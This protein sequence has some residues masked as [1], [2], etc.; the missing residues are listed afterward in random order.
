MNNRITQPVSS[1]SRPLLYRGL[2]LPTLATLLLVLGALVGR[3]ALAEAPLAHGQGLLWKVESEGTAPSYL[4]G[5]MHVTDPG[6]TELP[7]PV[8]KAFEKAHS[9][10]LEMIFDQEVL[11]RM[12]A[13]MMLADGRTL[14]RILGP[15]RFQALTTVAQRYGFP[16]EALV[17]FKPWAAMMLFSVPPEEMARNAAGTLPL[18]RR[19]QQEAQRRGKA[20]YGLE[21]VDEQMGV[22][23]SVPEAE[24]ISLLDLSMQE[25]QHIE[26]WYLRMKEAYLARDTAALYR[27]MQEQTAGSD[28][29]LMQA[30]EERLIHSRNR[31]MA[32]RMTDMLNQGNAFIAVGALHLP[33]ETGIL[34][35]L[36]QDGRR[37]TRVY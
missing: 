3:P 9:V 30:F 34:R 37:V 25:N 33:G 7:V 4:Y 28:P 24:Q 1:V 12:G 8:W 10:T 36:E 20:V 2:V 32:G 11:Q 16:R 27:F 31:L 35:L 23:E 14:D 17:L 21:S 18:D 26:A 29:A 19:L 13:A 15:E 5:T 6:I 22:F